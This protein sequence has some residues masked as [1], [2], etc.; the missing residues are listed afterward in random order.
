MKD[1][2]FPRVLTRTAFSLRAH[3]EEHFYTQGYPLTMPQWVLLHVLRH[4]DGIPQKEIA[5][6]AFKDKTNVAR[7]LASLEDSGLVIRRKDPQDRRSYQVSLT[8]KGRQLETTLQQIM[9]REMDQATVG[10]PRP[11]LKITLRTLQQI[12]QHLSLE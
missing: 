4:R 12:L 8:K 5:R 1:S 6:R 11:D 9:T 3:L 7:I 2:K 10:I